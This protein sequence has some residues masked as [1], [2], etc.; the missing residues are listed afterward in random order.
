MPFHELVDAHADRIRIDLQQSVIEHRCRSRPPRPSSREAVV[1]TAR[2]GR[3]C[4][5]RR[6]TPPPGWRRAG[7]PGRILRAQVGWVV[8]PWMRHSLLKLLRPWRTRVGGGSPFG[9]KARPSYGASPSEG[10]SGVVGPPGVPSSHR[11]ALFPLGKCCWNL[12]LLLAA[13]IWTS[14]LVNSL[15]RPS[16]APSLNLQ[17]EVRLLA[18][19][20]CR[21]RLVPHCWGARTR[22]PCC[23]ALGTPRRI[24]PSVRPSCWLPSMRWFLPE[25]APADDPLLK[26]LLCE[27][28]WPPGR[29]LNPAVARGAACVCP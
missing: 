17:Q 12:S 20:L 8:A 25:I 5:S 7:G 29:L 26:Q 14:G 6:R 2:C 18:D 16:V 19:R 4:R 28:R 11:Q 15:S 23:W 13:L 9:I 10:Q 21:T 27:A 3:G 24:G 22:A 1:D